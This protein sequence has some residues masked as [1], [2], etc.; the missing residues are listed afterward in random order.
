M[1]LGALTVDMVQK[2][3][4]IGAPVWLNMSRGCARRL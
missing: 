2:A 3:A 1:N 4:M